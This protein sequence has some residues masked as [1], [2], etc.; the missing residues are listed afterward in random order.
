MN[1]NKTQ[2]QSLLLTWTTLA[3]STAFEVSNQTL[4]ADIDKAP[5][6]Y[7]RIIRGILTITYDYL[8]LLTYSTYDYSRLLMERGTPP[9]LR[10]PLLPLPPVKGVFQGRR[11]V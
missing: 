1:T 11:L 6:D 9:H 5:S 7:L 4:Q 3:V 2:P 10:P 8:R